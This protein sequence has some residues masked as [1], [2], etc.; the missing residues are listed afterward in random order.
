MAL[1]ML[2]LYSTS[3]KTRS[4]NRGMR[5]SMGVSDQSA[6]TLVEVV[7]SLA[8]IGLVMA[9]V[10]SGYTMC[11]RRS[12]WSVLS[13]AAQS[14]AA[15]RMEQCVSVRWLPQYNIDNLVGTSFLPTTNNL[16]TPVTR[17]N[18]VYGTNFTT[19]NQISTYPPLKLIRVDCAW[20]FLGAAHT[21]TVVTIRA[22][23][24]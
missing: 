23:N 22:P 6:L 18:M 21:N 4:I 16:C 15:A 13:F 11:T 20:S 14:S 8:I 5:L 17:G 24:L 2:E 1:Y 9:G 3:M 10:I 12:T 7:L 19:I